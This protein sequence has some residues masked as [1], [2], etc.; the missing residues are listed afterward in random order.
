M[1]TTDAGASWMCGTDLQRLDKENDVLL[2]SE[3]EDFISRAACVDER[4]MQERARND[5]LLAPVCVRVE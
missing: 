1:T 4:A 5:L 2:F 3:Q